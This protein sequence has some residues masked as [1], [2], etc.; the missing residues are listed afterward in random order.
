MAKRS[1]S[2]SQKA[3]AEKLRDRTGQLEHLFWAIRRLVHKPDGGETDFE[4]RLLAEL[5]HKLASDLREDLDLF[6]LELPVRSGNFLRPE[7]PPPEP[8]VPDPSTAP[9]SRRTRPTGRAKGKSQA[10]GSPALHLVPAAR[11]SVEGSD[12][13][14]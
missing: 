3:D 1:L 4:V 11:P 10:S 2:G 14:A 5:G 12:H 8:V 9:T 13:A 7:E 6:S